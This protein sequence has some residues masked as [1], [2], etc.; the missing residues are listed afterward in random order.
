[1]PRSVLGRRGFV[2]PSDKLNIAGIGAGGK[3]ESDIAEMAK[4]PHV[5]IVALC[6]VDDRQVVNS[7]KKFPK[8][9]YYKDFREMLQ[10]EKNNIDA[11]TISTPDHTH[12]VATF[13]CHAIRETCV[14]AKPLTHDIYEARILAQA[15]K[16][17]KVVTQMGNQGASGDGVRQSKEI[18]EAGIIGDVYEVHA[19]TNRP[20]WP[21]GVPKPTGNH[22][23]PKELDWNLW[24]GTAKADDYNRLMYPL[25]GAVSGLMEQVH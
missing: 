23:I 4:S 5:N 12:A 10:K 3:G 20:I 8:A 17:Y 25:T 9:N 21:Q 24:Q 18:C 2:A 7:R 6:D 16:K 22:P 1:M 14:H 15:A 11:C 13:S 19:W